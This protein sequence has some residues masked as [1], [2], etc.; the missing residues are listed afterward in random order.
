M[1]LYSSG[2]II[3][4]FTGRMEMNRGKKIVV[5]SHCIIN[6]NSKVEGLSTYS[7]AVK[8]MVNFFM[9]SGVGMMQLPCPEMEI[10]GIKRWGHV[11]EQFDTDHFRKTSRE[12]LKSTVGQLQNYIRNGYEV[13]GLVGID[14]SPSC[15]VEKTCSSRIWG[16]ETSDKEE[17]W[18][19]IQSVEIVNGRGV[20]IEEFLKLADESGIDVELFS[21][22][23]SNISESV[24]SL[25]KKIK[26]D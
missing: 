16:G 22:D 19:R 25:I 17:F 1:N 20:F 9:D 8:S 4:F 3:V 5:L 24:E 13:I 18:K 14:G 23:E 10:Y 11:K 15:G 26:T 2:D 21:L 6:A 12:M 7:S